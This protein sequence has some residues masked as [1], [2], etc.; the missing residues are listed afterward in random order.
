[1]LTET[2]LA[3]LFL[4]II[5]IK[6]A[7]EL[8]PMPLS[9][10][11][12]KIIFILFILTCLSTPLYAQAT[13]AIVVPAHLRPYLDVVDGFKT[14]LKQEIDIYF[15]D[16]NQLLIKHKLQSKPWLAVIAI[17]SQAVSF[18]NTLQIKA[19]HYIY[20]LIVYPES[21]K[22][23]K[24]FS[25]GIYLPLPPDQILSVIQEKIPQ[26]KKIVIPFSSSEGK[27]YVKNII[28][29]G[30]KKHFKIIPLAFH[31]KDILSLLNQMWADFDAI[32][33]IPDPIFSSETIIK[34][35]I[36]QA[37]MHKKAVI[38]YNRFFLEQGALLCFIVDFKKTGVK[39]ASLLT[40]ILQ[41]G[42][43][44][45]QPAFFN[46]HI[47]KQVWKYLYGKER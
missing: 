28:S 37:I 10:L 35:F 47:N 25:C 19:K 32:L 41:T 21:L 12:P 20:S 13:I 9:R 23:N 6:S 22:T 24:K 14:Q 26:I 2:K 16:N 43:C 45:S 34:F 33:F 29:I 15:L 18:L 30:E 7:V 1:M 4:A 27:H 5:G 11:I 38:G 42:V 8:Y 3:I 17:G 40:Q 36:Q 39:T 44:V 46:I 31:H